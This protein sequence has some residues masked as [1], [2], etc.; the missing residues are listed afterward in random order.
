MRPPASAVGVN[1]FLLGEGSEILALPQL[2]EDVL[3]L[4]RGTHDEHSQRDFVGGRSSAQAEESAKPDADNR[5]TTAS[6]HARFNTLENKQPAFS[7]TVVI[8]T[9]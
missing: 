5:G 4:L 3:R 2:A 7:A 1:G 6:T 8:T 9:V